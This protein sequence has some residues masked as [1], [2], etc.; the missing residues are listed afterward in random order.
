[1]TAKL[2]DRQAEL[3]EEIQTQSEK[4]GKAVLFPQHIAFKLKASE[5]DILMDLTVLEAAGKIRK[6]GKPQVVKGEQ[7]GVPDAIGF[8]VAPILSGAERVRR[9]R[10]AQKL[11][12]RKKC[13][14]WVTPEEED[15]VKK[16][17]ED[18]RKNGPSLF[19]E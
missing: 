10:E 6:V 8:C 17:L 2:T 7:D 19:D 11:K 5:G 1:M 4:D 15:A 16:F 12:G 13:E 18:L 9:Y 14:L 3:L